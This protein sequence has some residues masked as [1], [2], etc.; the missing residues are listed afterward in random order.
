MRRKLQDNLRAVRNRIADAC[1]RVRRNPDDVR[2]V[3]VTKT[4][5]I[6]VIRTLIDMGV[7]DLG[8]NRAQE[9]VRRAGM[10]KEQ[11]SRRAFVGEEAVAPSVRWHMIGNLQRNKVKGLLPSVAL[12]QSVDRLRLVEEISKHAEQQSR[13]VEV[14]L[15][16]NG[17]NEVQKSGTAVCAAPHLAE[18]MAAMPNLSLRGLMSMAPLHADE[19]ELRNTFTRVA[20]LFQEMRDDYALGDRFDTLSMGMSN[21][22]EIAIEC[23][24]N[25]VRIGSAL[26]KGVAVPQSETSHASP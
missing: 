18:Q 16:I 7:E 9:L 23:G 1:E 12:I 6:D 10:L 11:D 20:E 17:G 21:D 15:E 22:F 13:V 8:E 2:L 24:A 4:V 5:G 14:L 19:T 26:L 25:V 3:A